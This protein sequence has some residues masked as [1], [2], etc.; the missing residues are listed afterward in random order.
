MSHDEAELSTTTYYVVINGEE[1]YSIWPTHKSV[2]L[3]W[4]CVGVEGSKQRC[5][6]HIEAT[7]KDMRPASLRGRLQ[8]QS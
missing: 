6:E 8:V 4:T 3:G 5:L 7:W 2:P 1:Q